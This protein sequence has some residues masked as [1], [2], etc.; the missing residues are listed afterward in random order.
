MLWTAVGA[1]ATLAFPAATSVFDQTQHAFFVAA[2]CYL[3]FLAARR[4][5]MRLAIAGGVALAILVNFQETYAILFPTIGMATLAAPGASPEQRRRSLERYIVFMFVGGIGLLVWAGLNNF[6][7][8]SLLLSGK[9]G[10]NHPSPYGNPLIGIAGLLFSPGKSI[11][12]YSPP[13]VLALL[14]LWN[15]S[16]GER[17]LGQ[18][19]VATAAAYL[20]LISSLS[21]F[22][23]DWCWGPRYFVSI[24]PLL[25]LGFP[26]LRFDTTPR[27]LAVGTLL[28][29]GLAVQFLGIS[30]DQH[31]FFYG[32]SLRPFFWST[33]RSFYFR[34]SALFARPAEL[35]TRMRDGVPREAELF[36][37]GPYP[38]AD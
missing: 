27:R 3:A 21:F 33:D 29:S 10:G 23:G 2:A 8:G 5:S 38:R 30:I 18:A 7:F 28:V 13:T 1:F 12:L 6:R 4:D 15:L 35:L 37:P 32:R 19:I 16:R 24:L 20:A 31:P 36:R 9:G 25:A 34:E 26:F 14:G 22:G 11:F 17:R